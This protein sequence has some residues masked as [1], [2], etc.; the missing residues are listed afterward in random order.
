MT[1]AAQKRPPSRVIVN[2]TIAPDPGRQAQ[3]RTE[4]PTIFD[5]FQSCKAAEIMVFGFAFRDQLSLVERQDLPG[6]HHGL[7]PYQ[8]G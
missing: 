5:G 7:S 3:D 6:G 4:A 2:K 1:I 8:V